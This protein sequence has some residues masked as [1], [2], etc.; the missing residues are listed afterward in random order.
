MARGTGHV[1]RVVVPLRFRRERP[2]F[3]LSCYM[4]G[5]DTQASIHSSLESDVS[6]DSDTPP[7]S[8]RCHRGLG[9]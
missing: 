1:R 9:W 6:P 2:I 3:Y 5:T 4:L 8:K 7:G